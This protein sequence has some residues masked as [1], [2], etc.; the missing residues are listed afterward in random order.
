MLVVAGAVADV[1]AAAAV[2]AVVVV[3]VVVVV[4]AVL[5]LL[6]VAAAA[7]AASVIVVVGQCPWNEVNKSKDGQ[8]KKQQ[9]NNRKILKKN[10]EME[11]EKNPWE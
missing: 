4:V 1:A 6:V 9:Q 10:I 8:L 11:N 3:V 2:V 7:A 5:L